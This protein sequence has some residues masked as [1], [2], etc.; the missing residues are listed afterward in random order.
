MELVSHKGKLRT[1]HRLPRKKK[2]ELKKLRKAFTNSL[3]CKTIALSTF[4]LGGIAIYRAIKEKIKRDNQL[5][6]EQ[7]STC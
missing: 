1:K 4:V 3:I 5:I 7:E 2:K 6:K